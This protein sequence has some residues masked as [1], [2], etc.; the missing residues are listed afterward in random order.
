[1]SKDLE[2]VRPDQP[3]GEARALLEKNRIRQVPV[4]RRGTL[5]GIVTHRDLCATSDEAAKIADV[6][7]HSLHTVAPD[8]TVEHAARL[9]RWWKFNALP[10]VQAKKL[11][12]IVSTT[13]ILDA[14]LCLSAAGEPSY[15]L[16]LNPP[17]GKVDV[18]P[19]CAL[20]ERSHG[21]VK[22]L[23]MHGRG[24]GREVHLRVV[25]PSIDEVTTALEAANFEVLRVVSS[26]QPDSSG[27]GPLG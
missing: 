9:L 7:T 27:G 3:V 20:I 21:D 5:V 19:L 25:T 4:L 14:F 10:V 2:T 11:V 12:G 26:M 17:P 1:M 8:D 15:Q 13:D 18:P 6:M 24:S 23:Q 16:V 22:S